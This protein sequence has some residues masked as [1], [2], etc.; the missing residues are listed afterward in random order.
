MSSRKRTDPAPTEAPT[1]P[2]GDRARAQDRLKR[3]QEAAAQSRQAAADAESAAESKRQAALEEER[4]LQEAEEEDAREQER[5]QAEQAKKEELAQK[6]EARKASAE[7][8]KKETKRVADE[9]KAKAK[10]KVAGT[11][12]SS[13]SAKKGP[14][15]EAGKKGAALG[16]AEGSEGAVQELDEDAPVIG[17]MLHLFIFICFTDAFLV[18]RTR[19]RAA[20]GHLRGISSA[21]M[22][23]KRHLQQVSPFGVNCISSK[24]SGSYQV[25]EKDPGDDQRGWGEY[26]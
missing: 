4:L 18:S 24:F 2:A 22:T 26:R 9:K 8:K 1:A 19:T 10:A 15:A 16:V 3:L 23:R 7:A 11:T 14:G 17:G 25:D 12:E 21:Q 5:I 13:A 20:G 6:A